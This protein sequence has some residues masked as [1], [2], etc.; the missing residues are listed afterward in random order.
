MSTSDSQNCTDIY[1]DSN[2]LLPI[3]FDNEDGVQRS[4]ISIPLE[5]ASLTTQAI[6]QLDDERVTDEMIKTLAARL[7]SARDMPGIENGSGTGTA[8][9]EID[10]NCYLLAL[11]L[12]TIIKNY[13]NPYL[14]DLAPWFMPFVPGNQPNADNN[15]YEAI[16]EKTDSDPDHAL[17]LN[18][19]SRIYDSQ[20]EFLNDE[21]DKKHRAM[22]MLPDG[23]TIAPTIIPKPR[24]RPKPSA[25][26]ERPDEL[27]N[28]CVAKVEQITGYL[29]NN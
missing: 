7:C 16:K 29:L 9:I 8:F 21:L 12:Q 4:L 28:M 23:L 25:W 10:N 22:L 17:F 3:I 2:T 1:L 26:M 18:N 24:P 6:N 27:A 20:I 5:N 11:H 19:L 13:P 15:V 14:F